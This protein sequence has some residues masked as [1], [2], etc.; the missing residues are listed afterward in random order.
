[1]VVGCVAALLL[2]AGMRE[3]QAKPVGTTLFSEFLVAVDA[4]GL[5]WQWSNM[6]DA[7]KDWLEARTMVGWARRRVL[8]RYGA[9]VIRS[10]VL[11]LALALALTALLFPIPAPAPSTVVG[12]VLGG[13]LTVYLTVSEVGFAWLA[14]RDFRARRAGR[15]EMA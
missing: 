13:E 14:W 15:A 6:L 3:W 10:V 12:N 5:R 7:H 8:N 4:F 2:A 1:M 9:N 11:P